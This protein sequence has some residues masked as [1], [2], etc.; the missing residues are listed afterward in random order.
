MFLSKRD[1]V[2]SQAWRHGI[3][4]VD[5]ADSSNPQVFYKTTRDQ[6]D[7]VVGDKDLI[8]KRRTKCK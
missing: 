6:K 7:K 4:G 8:N 3:V 2:L 1:R 5:D